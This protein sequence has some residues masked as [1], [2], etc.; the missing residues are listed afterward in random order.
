MASAEIV[1]TLA[2]E[3]GVPVNT[4][5]PLLAAYHK[6]LR[7]EVVSGKIYT[8]AHFGTFEIITKMPRISMNIR[9]GE[10][11]IKA[12]TR[13]LVFTPSVPMKAAI[14]DAHRGNL[15]I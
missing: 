12:E 13:K 6:L 14:E 1:K 15:D 5:R 8:M 10:D 4:L 7:D 11:R 9:T 3:Y 2:K